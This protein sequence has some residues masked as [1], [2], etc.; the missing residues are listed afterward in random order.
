VEAYAKEERACGVNLNGRLAGGVDLDS[1]RVVEAHTEEERA[2]GMNLDSGRT[3]GID[4]DD[5][6][7]VEAHA[8]EE[9]G[10][11]VEA[12]SAASRR[13]WKRSGRQW[14]CGREM[15]VLGFRELVTLKKKNSSDEHDD[16]INVR[17]Y[18]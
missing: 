14:V 6:H 5:G 11:G 3:S 8:E 12:V 4:L 1:E 13:T 7:T 15:T 18:I 10:A 9:R 17:R 16:I 2:R